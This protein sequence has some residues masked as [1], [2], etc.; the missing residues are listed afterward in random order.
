MIKSSKVTFIEPELTILGLSPDLEE[1]MR[2][3][4][5]INKWDGLEE[6]ESK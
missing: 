1:G 3:V 2:I 5:P 6:E 4:I